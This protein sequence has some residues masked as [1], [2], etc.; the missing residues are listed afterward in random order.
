MSNAGL[1]Q[2]EMKSLGY[3][4]N[5]PRTGMLPAFGEFVREPECDTPQGE[6]WRNGRYDCVVADEIFEWN[7]KPHHGKRIQICNF[8]QSARH[9]WR[10]F[11]RIKN[12]L[13]GEQWE[14]V[15]IYPAESRLRDPSNAFYLWCFPPHTL[16]KV[17]FIGRLVCTPDN[18]M[19]PQRSFEK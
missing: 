1:S 7:G 17:G 10:D 6:A 12:A 19:A 11:Q 15:E 9:D 2:R 18:S 3:R 5:E 16:L 4:P 8:D 13:A 14:A